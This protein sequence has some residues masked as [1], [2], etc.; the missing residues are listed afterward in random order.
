M[1]EKSFNLVN[2]GKPIE[3]LIETISNGI[4]TLYRPSWRV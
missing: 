2:L 1:E 3:K 4:G